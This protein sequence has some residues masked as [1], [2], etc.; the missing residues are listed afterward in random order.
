MI[1]LTWRQHRL[2]AAGSALLLV[3]FVGLAVALVVAAQPLLDQIRQVCPSVDDSCGRAVMAWDLKFASMLQVLYL[4]YL[5]LPIL[6]GLFIGAPLLAREF[7]QGTDQLVWSQGITRGRWLLVKLA[8]L[9]GAIAVVAGILAVAGQMWS[10]SRPPMSY[11]QWYAFDTQGP[12]FVAYALFA[13]ALGVAA[14]AAFGK[15][16]PAMAAVMVGFVGAR[17]AIGLFARRNYLPPVESEAIATATVGPT[18]VATL[19]TGPS[20]AW[21]LGSQRPVDLQGNPIG[22][23]RFEEAIRTCNPKSPTGY[24]DMTS[25]WHE[26]GVKLVQA[27]QPADRFPLFQGIETAI[28]VIAAIA[29]LGLSVWLV[30]RRA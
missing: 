5:V 28:F 23:D 12:E 20:Q 8:I 18:S 19:Y 15:S 4:A 1:W 2:D 13:F 27:Y 10:T 3:V 16:V 30:R 17:V 6:S 14:G 29:L 9:G 22:M 24:T 26:H 25:C 7:E 21:M 11:S